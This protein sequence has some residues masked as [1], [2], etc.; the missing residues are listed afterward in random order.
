MMRRSCF[1]VVALLFLAS[2]AMAQT[3]FSANIAN[4]GK[5]KNAMTKVIRGK[6]KLF[7]NSADADGG[8]ILDLQNGTYYVLMPKQ[9]M[10]MVMPENMSESRGTFR[11]FAT[12]DVENACAE[13]LK[14]ADNTGGTCHKDGSETVNGRSTVKYDG[15]NAKGEASTVWLD[16][17]LRFPI[18]WEGK[19]GGGELQNI[20]EGPQP[21]SL[22]EIPA[23]YKKMDMSG[24][25]QRK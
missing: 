12:G 19:N 15:T 25:M 22:F 2:F 5:E 13:W 9:H 18:K 10:Y 20:Q 7:F 23:G 17:K 14:Q 8:V 16:S 24:M 6:D 3:E 1:V 21:D 4:H 11:F